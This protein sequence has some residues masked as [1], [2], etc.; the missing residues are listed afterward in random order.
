MCRFATKIVLE[1]VYGPKIAADVDQY[2]GLQER[3]NEMLAE[4]GDTSLLD[5]I[6]IRE[7]TSE[8]S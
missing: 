3:K 5:L 2:I 1:I 4:M 6:P 7:P 8:V